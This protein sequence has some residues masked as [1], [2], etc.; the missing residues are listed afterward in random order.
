[1]VQIDTREEASGGLMG[2]LARSL[3]RTAASLLSTSLFLTVI[4]RERI[5]YAQTSDS[6]ALAQT[7]FK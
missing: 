7:F 4:M 3:A 6:P 2:A 1:M 5:N